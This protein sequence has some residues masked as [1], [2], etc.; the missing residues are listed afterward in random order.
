MKAVAAK[1]KALQQKYPNLALM[2]EED[3]K[4]AE[5]AGEAAEKSSERFVKALMAVAMKYPNSPAVMKAYE[6]LG[7]IG[8][9]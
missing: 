4:L 8:S 1:A 3:G 5:G 2:S 9:E 6:K 7:E